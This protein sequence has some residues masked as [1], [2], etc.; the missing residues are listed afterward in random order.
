MRLAG[1]EEGGIYPYPIHVAEACKRG[2][3]S[4]FIPPSPGICG[5]ILDPCAAEGKIASALG[6]LLKCETLRGS[7]RAKPGAASC[8]PA[9][10]RS[11]LRQNMG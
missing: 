11:R 8:S 6:Q 3:A 10:L 5:P 9:A 1:M 2:G 7:L 4:W